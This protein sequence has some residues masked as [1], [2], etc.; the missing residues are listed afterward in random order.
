[1]SV[2]TADDLKRRGDRDKEEAIKLLNN[3]FGLEETSE[4]VEVRT[5]VEKIINASLYYSAELQTR[6]L[7]GGRK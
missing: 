1:M 2:L 3:M 4:S 6:A 7:Q 5:I